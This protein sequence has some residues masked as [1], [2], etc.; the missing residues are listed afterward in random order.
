MKNYIVLFFVCG[1]LLSCG[2]EE[3]ESQTNPIFYSP[4]KP[5]PIYPRDVFQKFLPTDVI[6]FPTRSAIIDEIPDGDYSLRI[7]KVFI[8][9]KEIG[10][11]VTLYQWFKDS[12]PNSALLIKF[13]KGENEKKDFGYE[14]YGTSTIPVAFKKNRSFEQMTD[15]FLFSF[16]YKPYE[17]DLEFYAQDEIGSRFNLKLK[18]RQDDDRNWENALVVGPKKVSFFLRLLD[19]PYPNATRITYQFDYYK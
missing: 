8:E 12:R 7:L 3:E 13:D 11:R 2:K 14:A 1:I 15:T 10:T 4:V 9:N 16:I 5:A 6:D 19:L 18:E 17:E